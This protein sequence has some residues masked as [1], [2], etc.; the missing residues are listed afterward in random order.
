M[1]ETSSDNTSNM[2][3]EYA[4]R[5]DEAL[6]AL[7][8]EDRMLIDGVRFKILQDVDEKIDILKRLHV[9]DM[10]ILDV[11]SQCNEIYREQISPLRRSLAFRERM[12]LMVLILVLT[13]SLSVAVS[14]IVF[15]AMIKDG[16]SRIARGV[17]VAKTATAEAD[18]LWCRYDLSRALDAQ[19]KATETQATP[20][21]IRPDA[22][23]LGEQP[24][25]P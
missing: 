8:S 20:A 1:T 22:A 14:F 11:R 9:M 7:S 5:I 23:R 17:L 24:S 15:E 16:H 3:Q 4:K 2:T 6:G 12:S 18:Q 19:E 21:M 13:A 25:D 10:D